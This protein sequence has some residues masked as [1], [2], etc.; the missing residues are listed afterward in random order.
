MDMLP[1]NRVSY[2]ALFKNSTSPA[3]SSQR[4]VSQV[5]QIETEFSLAHPRA[6]RNHSKISQSSPGSKYKNKKKIIFFD[7]EN[8]VRFSNSVFLTFGNLYL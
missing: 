6:G 1:R 8:Q 7:S 4:D 2:D 5:T 3:A